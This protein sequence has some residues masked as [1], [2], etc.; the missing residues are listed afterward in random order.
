MIEPKRVIHYYIKVVCTYWQHGIF[1]INSQLLVNIYNF[2]VG[3]K[4]IQLR[5]LFSFIPQNANHLTILL[6]GDTL[7]R[8]AQLFLFFLGLLLRGGIL[9]I[10]KPSF[11]RANLQIKKE[12]QRKRFSLEYTGAVKP[13]TLWRKRRLSFKIPHRAYSEP[14][15]RI[16]N[17][18]YL[19]TEIGQIFH[20]ENIFNLKKNF[21]SWNITPYPLQHGNWPWWNN[22]P[23]GQ[24]S[25]EEIGTDQYPVWMTQKP[26]KGDLSELKSTTFPLGSMPRIPLEACALGARLGNRSV[27]ILDPR[28]SCHQWKFKIWRV[29]ILGR[30]RL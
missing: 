12:E 23:I 17:G 21:P 19:L 27:F 3:T 11:E 6:A 22:P 18:F 4:L 1:L 9:K 14:K 15:A 26:R 5:F 28:L 8:K 2:A 10:A 13:K 24:A 16:H 29:G 25:S 20:N 30:R 7:I